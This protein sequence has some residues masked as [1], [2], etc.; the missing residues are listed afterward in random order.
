MLVFRA[1]WLL[2]LAAVL[3]L[4]ACAPRLGEARL[5]WEPPQPEGAAAPHIAGYRVAWGASAQGPFDLGE[6][7]VGAATT[8][9]TIRDL[10]PGTYCFVVYSRA[11]GGVESAPTGAV[12]KQV[13][14]ASR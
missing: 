8:A 9:L 11:D 2:R 10:K 5:A 1:A 7:Q 6:Q 13:V 12:C 3:C 4:V 14:T